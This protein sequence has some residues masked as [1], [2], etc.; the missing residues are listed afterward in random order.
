MH[1]AAL[2]T[3]HNGTIADDSAMDLAE[4]DAGGQRGHGTPLLYLSKESSLSGWKVTAPCYE[5]QMT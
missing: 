1:H 3:D 4:F 2:A 5:A